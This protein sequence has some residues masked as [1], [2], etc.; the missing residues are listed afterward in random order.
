MFRDAALSISSVNSDRYSFEHFEGL[1][2][3]NDK[4]M[5]RMSADQSVGHIHC[6]S[7]CIPGSILQQAVWAPF[8]FYPLASLELKT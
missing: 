7:S 3:L 2:A 8:A 5:T 6:T 4:L 1:T